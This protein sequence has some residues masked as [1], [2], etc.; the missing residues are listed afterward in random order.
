MNNKIPNPV[1]DSRVRTDF[2][3][4]VEYLKNKGG[5]TKAEFNK[6][7][8]L[9]CGVTKNNRGHAYWNSTGY[10]KFCVPFWAYQKQA[11]HK[12]R[13]IFR[14]TPRINSY[15]VYYIAH[16]ISH[17]LNDPKLQSHGHEF[18]KIFTRVCPIEL[19]HYE[20]GYKTKTASKYI[21][22]SK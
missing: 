4:A 19:Q 22:E 9:V 20:L 2:W 14:I 6:I 12:G 21:K 10:Y 18:Y 17:V 1:K 3:S 16:E 11:P 7:T 5:L 13:K 8:S 15:F